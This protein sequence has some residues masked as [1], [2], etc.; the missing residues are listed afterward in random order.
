[1]CSKGFSRRRSRMNTEGLPTQALKRKK[2]RRLKKRKLQDYKRTDQYETSM[3]KARKQLAAPENTTQF[4]MDDREQLE[5][6]DFTTTSPCS[7]C[8]NSTSSVR[9]SPVD[10]HEFDY[11]SDFE[12]NFDQVYFEKD[13]NDMYDNIHAETLFS[14]TKQELINRYMNL[15]KRE[16]ELLKR[17]RLINCEE[18]METPFMDLM[19]SESTTSTKMMAPTTAE[20]ASC[21]SIDNRSLVSQRDDLRNTNPQLAQE[22]ERLR[23]C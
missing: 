7:S 11:C 21:R 12:E 15:E 1:M 3:K 23:G 14:L 19:T 13:F 8:S 9:G 17:I 4:I 6:F 10:E 18:K 22:N 16:E 5:P 20:S 2:T